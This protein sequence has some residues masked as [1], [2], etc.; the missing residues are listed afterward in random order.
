MNLGTFRSEFPV[1][2]ARSYLF[3]GGLAPAAR[4][5]VAAIEAWIRH[6]ADDP[7]YHRSRYY[8]DLEEVRRLLALLIGCAPDSVALMDSTS[9]ASNAWLSAFVCPVGANV[10]VDSTTYPSS[11][12]PWLLPQRHVE[13]RRAANISGTSEVNTNSIAELVDDE[14]VAVSISHVSPDTGFKH[15]LRV[16]SEIAHAHGAIFAVDAAQSVGVEPVDVGKM[17]VDVLAGVSMKWLLGPPGIS[18]LYVNPDLLGRLPPAEASYT[19]SVLDEHGRLQ[20]KPGARRYEHGIGNLMGMAGL[21]AALSLL[22]DVGVDSI[23]KRVRELT[24]HLLDAFTARQLP[25]LTPPDPA[26]RAG[27]VVLEA[28]RAEL[29]STF[30]HERKVDTWGYDST[31][32]VRIDPHGFNTIDDIDRLLQGLDEFVELYGEEAIHNGSR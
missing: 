5:V 12:Y 14:T 32:R 16:I 29:L 13:L 10:V 28:E 24:T 17:G 11:A 26:K 15:N 6:W 25:V 8:D 19:S 4:P 27:I 23:E 3:S 21:R 18:F 9:R 7:R 2:R 20:F 22:H 31:R 30:L 1:T